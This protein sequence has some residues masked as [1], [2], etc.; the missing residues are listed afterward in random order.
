VVRSY[1]S[2]CICFNFAWWE[3]C[4]RWLLLHLPCIM[5]GVR[6]PAFHKP[7]LARPRSGGFGTLT[8]RRLSMDAVLER[9]GLR[10]H[11]SALVCSE[12]GAPPPSAFRCPHIYL[13]Q[14]RKAP[15]LGCVYVSRP[16]ICCVST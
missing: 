1:E 12:D 10:H 2:P 6:F 4:H 11:F 8:P 16:S 9:M 15:Q 3:W 5:Q 13:M 7:D 14:A